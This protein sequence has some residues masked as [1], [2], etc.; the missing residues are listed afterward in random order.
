MDQRRAIRLIAVVEAAK[1]ILILAAGFGLLSLLHSNLHDLAVRLIDHSHL[2]PASK[3]PQIF[4]DA[5]SKIQD[6]RLILL[7]IGAGAYSALRL[8]EAY[9]LFYE[10]AWAELLAAGSGAIYLP[11][12]LLRFIRH[13][14]WLGAALFLANIAIVAIMVRALLRRR[15]GVGSPAS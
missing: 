11:F 8:V 4:I 5:A 6:S 1:G 15:K 3:Y 7:A 12:E 10:K 9:G 14:N 13:P 2:N